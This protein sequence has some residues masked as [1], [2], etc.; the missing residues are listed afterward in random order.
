[1][2][3]LPFQRQWQ[4]RSRVFAWDREGGGISWWL[5]T[6]HQKSSRPHWFVHLLCD[7]PALW[8]Q[9]NESQIFHV[10]NK[11]WVWT[12][13]CFPLPFRS[14]WTL[15]FY[16]QNHIWEFPGGSAVND[17]LLSLLWL[18]FNPWSGNFHMLWVWPK[19]WVNKNK[20]ITLNPIFYFF[21][22][23]LVFH[24]NHFRKHITFKIGNDHVNHWVLSGSLAHLGSQG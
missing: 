15:K 13:S 1:M 5:R 16:N 6:S 18:R 14:F 9:A 21:W 23:F 12:V 11:G 8:F 3:K 19:K 7:W 22:F 10:L 17:P 20:R 2:S 24:C 4:I